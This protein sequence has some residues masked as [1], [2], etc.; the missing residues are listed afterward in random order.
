MFFTRF[1]FL[2]ACLCGVLSQ[3]HAAEPAGGVFFRTLGMD[4]ITGEIYYR[5]GG[6]D[7]AVAVDSQCRSVYYGYNGPLAEL[8]FF[9]LVPGTD[10]KPVPQAVGSV[11]LSGLGKRPLLLFIPQANKPGAYVVRGFEDSSRD[12]A[13]G[14]YRFVNLTACRIGVTLGPEKL[15]IPANGEGVLA[16]KPN[17]GGAASQVVVYGIIDQAPLAVYSS[18]WT[19]NAKR[20]STIIIVSSPSRA[21][22]IEVRCLPESTDNIPAE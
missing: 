19:Y 4:S 5:S 8:V 11:N 12:V 13:P 18:I 20:R 21:T 6:K 7:L 14:G 17:G 10:G 1:P 16:S 15:L 9:R 2:V 3:I 22:G